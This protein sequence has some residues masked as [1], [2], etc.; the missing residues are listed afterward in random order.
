[1]KEIN[2]KSNKKREH[3]ALL[4]RLEIGLN[5]DGNILFNYDW[6]KPEKVIEAMEDH[7]YRHTVSAVIRHCLSNSHKLDHD[8]K[9][10][11]RNI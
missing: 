3:E 5:T 6:V 7:E 2:L 9:N 11:L 10:L 1:M 8:I 4:F